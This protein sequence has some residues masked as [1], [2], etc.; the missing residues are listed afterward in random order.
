MRGR[1]ALVGKQ[2]R[3]KEDREKHASKSVEGEKALQPV[4]TGARDLALAR[5]E[6]WHIIV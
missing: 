4:L 3:E 2:R 5:S 6:D 1:A